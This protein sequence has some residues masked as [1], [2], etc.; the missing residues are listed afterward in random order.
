MIAAGNDGVFQRLCDG[1]HMSGLCTDERFTTVADRRRNRAELHEVIE[2]R[3][4]QMTTAEVEREL[5]EAGVPVSAVNRLDDALRTPLAAERELLCE[6]EGAPA[7]PR[8]A[9]LARLPIL[10]PE[11]P[12]AWPPGL[13]ADNESVLHE[14]GLEANEIADALGLERASRG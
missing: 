14:A 3:L 10:P 12:L 5:G 1:M 13:G 11:V 9:L 8:E 6:P 2:A 4:R 7:G